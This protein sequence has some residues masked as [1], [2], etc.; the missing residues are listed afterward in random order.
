MTFY[1][2]QSFSAIAGQY[3]FVTPCRKSGIDYQV[4]FMIIIPSAWVE[5]V[6]VSSIRPGSMSNFW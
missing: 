6:A 4:N 1:M 3:E 2:G 5:L